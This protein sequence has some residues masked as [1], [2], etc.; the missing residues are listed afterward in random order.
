[1]NIE[2]QRT[3]FEAWAKRQHLP[4]SRSQITNCGYDYLGVKT[5]AAWLAWLESA[6]QTSAD[7]SPSR[8]YRGC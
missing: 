3:R 4:N 2:E 8:V 5:E 7:N 1:M 6:R